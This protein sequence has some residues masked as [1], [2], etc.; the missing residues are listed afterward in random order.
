MNIIKSIH[1]Y[2]LIFVALA[3]YGRVAIAQESPKEEDCFSIVKVATPEGSSLEVGG[4]VVLPN[5]DLAVATRRGDI[6]IVKNPGSRKPYF[7]KFASGLHEVLGL[8]YKDGALY[9]AQR[10]G[11]DQTGRYQ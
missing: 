5:G 2:T 8:A 11:T 3:L 6:F 1:R 4:L 10:G 9:C 7:Q